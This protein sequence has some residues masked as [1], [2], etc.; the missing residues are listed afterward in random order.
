[1]T[2]TFIFGNDK[3]MSSWCKPVLCYKIALKYVIE[4]RNVKEAQ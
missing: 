3:S 1:M 2:T 4:Q